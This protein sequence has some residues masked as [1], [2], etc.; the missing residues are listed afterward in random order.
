M[1]E[2]NNKEKQSFFHR[3]KNDKK[4]KAKVELIAYLVI[5]VVIV[6]YLNVSNIGNNYDYNKVTDTNIKDVLT[7]NVED[8][9]DMLKQLKDN[10]TYNI[11]ISVKS[12]GNNVEDKVVNNYSYSGKVYKD[13][14]IIDKN[15]NNTVYNYYKVMDEYYVKEGDIYKIIKDS[16]VYDLIDKKYIELNDVR[17]YIDKASLD[18]VTNYSSGKKEYVYNLKVK[19]VIGSYMEDD[20]VSII[21]VVENDSVVMSIDYT[22]LLMVIDDNI[23]DCKLVYTYKDINKVEEFTVMEDDESGQEK[24]SDN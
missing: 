9:G 16:D 24:D 2:N 19:D 20:V 8:T 15:L 12:K 4:Y 3:I 1:E 21:I 11:D 7:N 10:Y 17:K 18:H 14:M 5:I 22:N 6:I 23:I 13:N